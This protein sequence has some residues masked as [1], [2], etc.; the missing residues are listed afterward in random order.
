MKSKEVVPLQTKWAYFHCFVAPD[1][2]V[3]RFYSMVTPSSSTG[4]TLIYSSK[5][6]IDNNPRLKMT[7]MS[8][9]NRVVRETVIDP[10][11][12]TLYKLLI[13]AVI[14]TVF[15]EN[16]LSERSQTQKI[17]WSSRRSKVNL[18]WQRLTMN[19][20]WSVNNDM[21]GMASFCNA[22]NILYLDLMV[23][24]WL[25]VMDWMLCP[26]TIHMLKP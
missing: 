6:L 7:L 18:W 20:L 14:W 24:T 19:N 25:S 23:I 17:T 12:G 13:C 21:R 16:I 3:C 2:A 11:K 8:T 4:R 26:H 9:N 15:T 5:F 22:G 1:H 10:Q